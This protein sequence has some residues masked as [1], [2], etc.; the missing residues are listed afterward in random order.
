MPAM[1]MPYKVEDAK[2]LEGIDRRRSHRRDARRRQQRR[3][4]EGRQED[5]PG[6]ARAA[7]GD[8]QKTFSGFELLK[9]G[10]V[11]AEHHVSSIRTARRAISRSF[12]G[13]TL[14]LTFIYTKCPMPT[15]CPLMDRNFVAMQEQV[16]A[17]PALN[18]HLVTVS[19]DPVTDTPPVLKKHAKTLGADPTVWTFLTGERDDID[20]FAATVRRLGHAR[21]ERSARHHAQPADRDHRSHRATS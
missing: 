2:Q 18:V 13:S 15:F 7:A 20:K 19:F 12:T 3:L 6:A 21:D 9:E 17:D 16:K 11:G 4:S 10:A 8:V 14:V 1:T 5:R